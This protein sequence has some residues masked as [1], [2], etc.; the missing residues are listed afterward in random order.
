MTI[1]FIGVLR[2]FSILNYGLTYLLGSI[3]SCPAEDIFLCRLL[4][5][6]S[7]EGT[8]GDDCVRFVEEQLAQRHS[9]TRELFK[10]LEDT[11]KDQ[12]KKAESMSQGLHRNLS[13]EGQGI[14]N[15]Q[16]L[17]TYCYV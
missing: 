11:I 9:S 3:P 14:Y 16:Y 4:K 12:I 5:V 8:G 6:D 2:S 10:C 7:V 17:C 15:N 13:T 1:K